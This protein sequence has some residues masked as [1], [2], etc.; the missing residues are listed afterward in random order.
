MNMSSIP[1]N[2]TKVSLS[3]TAAFILTLAAAPFGRAASQP[4]ER[5]W[6]DVAASSL[7]PAANRLIVPAVYR[8]VRLDQT[9]LAQA[10]AAAPMEFTREASVNP[11]I[12]Y[13]PMPDGTM[14]RFRFEESPVI[15]PGLAAKF[16]NLKTFRAQG[17]DD[18][19]A[20]A[21][22]DWLTTGFHAIIL[23][24]SGTVLID[25]YAKGD[26]TNYITY[27]KRDAANLAE[28][29]CAIS[30]I[31]NRFRNRR[32]AEWR[33]R[34]LPARSCGPI[35]SRWPARWNMPRRWAAIP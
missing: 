34:L 17:I 26:T 27:W 19:A 5:M 1:S 33:R 7:D 6:Q 30:R 16:P 18:P 28:I 3:L 23:S 22:F 4:N 24:P 14:A 2:T 25:P 32:R 10:L 29:S 31:P 12:I 35:V 9:A 13:L 8:T 11:G 15:E 21:R 20:S